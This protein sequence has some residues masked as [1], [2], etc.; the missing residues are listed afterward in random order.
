[1]K[2][3]TLTARYNDMPLQQTI[4]AYVTADVDHKTRP[5]VAIVLVGQWLATLLYAGQGLEQSDWS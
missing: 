3:L 1:M 2:T 5:T 4:H